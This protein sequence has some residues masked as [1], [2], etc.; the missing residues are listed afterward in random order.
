MAS[1]VL[2]SLATILVKVNEE[3]FLPDYQEKKNEKEFCDQIKNIAAKLEA[4]DIDFMQW[5][6]QV[7][8]DKDALFKML[9]DL[10][11]ERPKS[12]EKARYLLT[13]AVNEVIKAVNKK[14]GNGNTEN[15]K[16]KVERLVIIIDDLDLVPSRAYAILE[17]IWTYLIRIENLV[18]VVA[19]EN[20][21]LNLVI[22]ES[23]KKQIF[24]KEPENDDV[25]IIDNLANALILK[26]FDK[27]F[28]LS[29]ISTEE[30]FELLSEY[31]GKNPQY[32][33]LMDEIKY[34]KEL[35]LYAWDSREI[36]DD[37]IE[38]YFDRIYYLPWTRDL[39]K[40][41]P[42]STREFIDFLL[43]IKNISSSKIRGISWYEWYNNVLKELVNK[44]NEKKN[45]PDLYEF[46]CLVSQL[47]SRTVLLISF[48]SLKCPWWDKFQLAPDDPSI[49]FVSSK[50]DPEEIKDL[51]KQFRENLLPPSE[52]DVSL[53][54]EEGYFYYTS[55]KQVKNKKSKGKKEQN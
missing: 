6:F 29:F 15:K 5:I 53:F 39:I 1:L 45:D 16:V 50:D 34:F 8:D 21:S 55:I 27:W 33:K 13:E 28:S 31:P 43:N 46:V 20:Q 17:D 38:K 7:A 54:I 24:F 30:K 25:K 49:L 22:K 19:F 42:F 12:A 40:I 3:K 36:K 41:L 32:E 44:N 35:L 18:I 47:L 37:E 23:L 14:L 11:M 51:K 52:K 26:T 48:I 9:H 2:E 4:H 10:S